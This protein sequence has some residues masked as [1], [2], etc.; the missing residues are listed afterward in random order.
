MYD[1][2]TVASP[3][4]RRRVALAYAALVIL[5]VVVLLALVAMGS[6][7]F[8]PTGAPLL[9]R[10]SALVPAAMALLRPS[11]LLGQLVVILAA[12]RLVGYLF[13]RI[14]QPRVLGE[15][16][17]G[18]LLGTSVLGALWP[19]GYELLFPRGSVRFLGALSQVGLILFMFLVGLEL[20]LSTVRRRAGVVLLTAHAGIAIPMVLGVA[21]SFYIFP[22][23][24]PTGTTFTG[25][26]LFIGIALAVTAFP[27]LARILATARWR[28][29][30]LADV[31][32]SCA[33][34]SDVTAW[35]ILA[36]VI[37][38]GRDTAT[39]LPLWVTLGGL[40]LF[41]LVMS[42][43]GRRAVALAADRLAS[44]GEEGV[45]EDTLAA[46]V[47]VALLCAVITELLGV[48][49]LFGSFL[50][51]VIMPRHRGVAASLELRLREVLAVVLLPI[52]FAST[53]I[54]LRL[55]L[56]GGEAMWVTCALVLVAAVAGKLGGSAIAA[57]A[58]GLG[59]RDSLSL[60]VMMNTRGLMELV[61]LN[62]G[63]D[64]GILSP[65]L[66]AIL[67]VMAFVTTLMTTPLLRVVDGVRPARSR[68]AAGAG[69]S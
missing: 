6:N 56:I 39:Q 54:R 62:I 17:A 12:T 14:G 25:F 31:A 64:A 29:A 43:I 8:P 65:S 61:V 63:L 24:A 20:D 49:A 2:S 13:A 67:V 26:A 44:G 9:P 16:I 21:A 4:G 46:V 66:Y 34:V 37:S 52:F 10:A 33:A 47:V 68:L 55:G 28:G 60:G 3:G 7:R 19:A 1:A 59:W 51:G 15:M 23:L 35:I 36:L 18:I 30:I 42:T 5:P 53:G 27:V 40:T 32:R 11:L 41:V 69:A 50:A 38:I 58:S 57:R 48:H 45:T 22:R